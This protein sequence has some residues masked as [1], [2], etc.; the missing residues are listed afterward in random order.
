MDFSVQVFQDLDTIQKYTN[1]IRL[2][3]SGCSLE[4]DLLLSQ[5]TTP[6]GLNLFL[7]VWLNGDKESDT[8]QIKGLLTALDMHP[9]A[10]LFAIAI[11]NESLLRGDLNEKQ[12]ILQIK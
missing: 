11:G 10:Q 5:S 8:A 2:Y 3:G 1:R 6:G 12:L 7:G 9:F 4:M